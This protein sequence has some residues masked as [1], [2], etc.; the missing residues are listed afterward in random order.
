[1]TAQT[2]YV[3]V[4]NEGIH[5]RYYNGSTNPYIETTHHPDGAKHFDT[6]DQAKKELNDLELEKFDPPFIVEEHEWL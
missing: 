2:A 6:Y 4:Q 1:M 5:K 3:I